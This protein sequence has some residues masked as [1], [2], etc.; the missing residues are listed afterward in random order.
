MAVYVQVCEGSCGTEGFNIYPA[1]RVVDKDYMLK[2]GD[3]FGFE[4]RRVEIRDEGFEQGHVVS[5]WF[6]REV[7]FRADDKVR[8]F[9]V[10]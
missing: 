5:R 4:F 2:G 9:E 10:G 6:E 7:G 8:G 1:G 3:G